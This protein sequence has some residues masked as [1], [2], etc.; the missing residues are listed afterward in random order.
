MTKAELKTSLKNSRHELGRL[1]TLVRT[2]ERRVDESERRCFHDR[3][4]VQQ[5]RPSTRLMLERALV[6]SEALLIERREM[7]AS[8]ITEREQ[9]LIEVQAL[10][11][12]YEA[13]PEPVVLEQ[14]IADVQPPVVREAAATLMVRLM[15]G[16]IKLVEIDMIR[17]VASFADE[18][19]QQHGYNPTVT[20]RM[21]FMILSEEEEKENTVFWSPEER[22]ADK[23]FAEMFVELEDEKSE[24]V[25]M[26]MLNLLIRPMEDG[27]EME[28]KVDLI[29][30]LLKELSLNDNYDDEI[31]FAMYGTW[32]LTYRPTTKGNRYLTMKAFINQ[33]G[34]A[35]WPLSEEDKSMQKEQQENR[36][37][38]KWARMLAYDMFHRCDSWTVEEFI[39]IRTRA[40]EMMKGND[41]DVVDQMNQSHENFT[42][43]HPFELV[44]LGVP[45]SQCKYTCSLPSC[46]ICNLAYWM[47][48]VGHIELP[49]NK[50]F[51][52][53]L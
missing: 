37:F 12:Q 19:A 28:T 30:K 21:V 51:N 49:Q 46:Y 24:D 17:P 4:R 5:A 53:M 22:H 7:F 15:S 20:S 3:H 27:R 10:E 11:E 8:R 13:M 38:R 33:N 36:Q 34:E 23:T 32:Y 41:R 35:F 18:F 44:H 47:N 6:R 39:R 29:R 2:L 40:F 31:L 25:S 9:L 48:R 14:Q 45:V 16:D 26:P 52:W 42:I 1:T 50:H 43:I